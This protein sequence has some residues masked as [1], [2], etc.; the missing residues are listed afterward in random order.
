MNMEF[1]VKDRWEEERHFLETHTPRSNPLEIIS[2]ENHEGIKN[3]VLLDDGLVERRGRS[4]G[5][6]EEQRRH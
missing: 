1:V 3:V 2:L 6:A 4:V 5:G